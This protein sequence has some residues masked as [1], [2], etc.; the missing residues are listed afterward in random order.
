MFGNLVVMIF[1]TYYSFYFF[2]IMK[3][4]NRIKIKETNNRLNELRN[5]P[6]KTVEEQKEF[7]NLKYPKRDKFKWHWMMIPRIIIYIVIFSLVFQVYNFLFS[8]LKL[9]L[10]LWIGILFV[11]IFPI[12]INLLLERFDLEKNDLRAFLGWKK[13]KQ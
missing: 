9:D 7:I 3:K 5:K 1:L 2:T 13:R 11:M 12:L 8:Y 4:K 6:L 10:P